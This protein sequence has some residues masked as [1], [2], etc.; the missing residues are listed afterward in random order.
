[1]N[2]KSKR[3]KIAEK[4]DLCSIKQKNPNHHLASRKRDRPPKFRQLEEA[5][6]IWCDAVVE[7]NEEYEDESPVSLALANESIDNVLRFIR[8]EYATKFVN[9]RLVV[10][11]RELHRMIKVLE[12][13]SKRQLHIDGFF[14]PQ[15]ETT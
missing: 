4:I 7:A 10:D 11:L 12:I 1:M 2:R 13:Q 15:S 9:H 6:A 3:Q 5:L 8:Q 14:A